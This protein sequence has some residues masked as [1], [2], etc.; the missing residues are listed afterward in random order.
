MKE[1]EL[2]RNVKM[3]TNHSFYGASDMVFRMS[4][5]RCVFL[6]AKRLTEF[7]L[8]CILL[9]P[10]V[11]TRGVEPESDIT[12]H[13]AHRTKTGL[14][15]VHGV[16]NGP[17][18]NEARVDLSERF[19]EIGV[20][21]VRL[22]DTDNPDSRYLVDISR[23]FPDFDADENDPANYYFTTTDRLLQAIARTGAQTIY[24][25]GESIDPGPEGRFAR[26]PKDF[27]KWA[28]ICLNVIRHYN[29]GWANGLHLNI[30]YWEIWN[31]PD[32][33]LDEVSSMWRGGTLEQV[34]R[35]YET[36]AVMIK[37]HDSTLRVGGM[38]FSGYNLAVCR[39]VEYCAER[40]LPLDFISFHWYF[41]HVE[42]LSVIAEQF[43]ALLEKHGYGAAERIFDEWNYLGH[44]ILYEEVKDTLWGAWNN[45]LLARDIS[46]YQ[47]NRVGASFV[48][49]AMI[50]MNDLPID[51]ATYYDAQT[52]SRFCGLFDSHGN[53]HKTFYGFKAY[54]ELYRR[55]LE[56]VEAES[57]SEGLHV[58]ANRN[59]VL[60]SNYLGKSHY[61]DMAF[62]GLGRGRKKAEIYVLNDDL[63]LEL[64]KTEYY[65]GDEV[66]QTCFVENYS[67]ILIKLSQE[68][69]E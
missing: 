48:T 25:L 14:K 34:C 32:N 40:R 33:C 6:P 8:C 63:D 55:G 29:D 15:P 36:A 68:E 52:V 4:D 24:R 47:K 2:K 67:V 62:K 13:F 57:R 44:E 12:I 20:P 16:T 51:I 10:S 49:A 56:R 64:Y 61:C 38:A 60:I 31:E 22:H 7:I 42:A 23:I 19:R 28:R 26:P 17:L 54:G 45:P 35:L 58:I 53:P 50:Y 65:H 11:Q 21:H 18:C 69:G 41:R 5:T 37:A 30:R 27:N 3:V 1:T 46:M 59:T 39:F 66:R 43:D 9:L